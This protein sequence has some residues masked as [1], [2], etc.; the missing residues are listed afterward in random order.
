MLFGIGIAINT[1]H[2][3]QIDGTASA[4]KL[5]PHKGLAALLLLFLF[6]PFGLGLG[7]AGN[8]SGIFGEPAPQEVRPVFSRDRTKLASAAPDGSITV[9]D[10]ESGW[11]FATLG[12]GLGPTT[13]LA[14]SPDSTILAGAN[15]NAVTLWDL[16]DGSEITVLAADPWHTVTGVAFSPRNEVLAAVVDDD[17]IAVWD[18][19]SEAVRAVLARKDEAVKQ[20]AFSADGRFLASHGSGPEITLWD[21]AAQPKSRSLSSPFDAPMTGLAF[22]P[23]GTTLA[24][25][26][27]DG[28]V[29]LW[30]TDTG[31]QTVLTAHID[32]IKRLNFSPNGTMLASEGMDARLVVWDLASG[33][34]LTALPARFDALVS[35]LAF[36]PDG[37]K[38]ASVGDDAELLVWE[39][40]SGRLLHV[41]WGHFGLVEELAFGASGQTL[42]SVGTDGQVIVWDLRTGVE[43][44]VLQHPGLDDAAD[45]AALV[46]DTA[47]VRV[48]NPDATTTAAA[49]TMANA[50]GRAPPDLQVTATKPAETA[51]AGITSLA[52]STDGST[53]ASA[54]E[55]GGIRLWSNTGEEQLVLAGHPGAIASSV[56]FSPNG[57]EFYSAGRDTQLR[58]WERKTAALTQVLLAHE[59]PI[60]A[61]ARSGD[62]NY[63]ASAGEETRV[64]VW[65]AKK[66]KLAHILSGGHKDFVNALAFKPNGNELASAGADGRIL[67]WAVKDGTLTDAL[68]GHAA[69][70]DALAYTGD[71]SMLASG[72]SDATVKLWDTKTGRQ[73]TSLAHPWPVKSIAISA[74]RKTLASAGQGTSIYVWDIQNGG[75]LI[76]VLDG[77]A[78]SVNAL[79]YLPNGRLLVGAEDGTITVWDVDSRQMLQVITPA[80][81]AQTGNM[82]EIPGPLDPECSGLACQQVERVAALSTAASSGNLLLEFAGR[83]LDWL[84]PA[85]S[86]QELRDPN[87]GPGGPILVLYSTSSLFGKYYAEILRT[88]GFNAFS[89]AD[90]ATVTPAALS[91]YD[92]VILAEMPLSADQAIMLTDWVSAG[93]NLIA[94][95][96][97]SQ[98][99]DLFGLT[100]TA[101]PPLSEGYLLIDTSAPPGNGIAGQTMQ[102]HGTATRYQLAGATAVATLYSDASTATDNPAVTLRDVGANG[103]Q[104]AAFAYDLA[105]SVVYT[106]QGNP[107]WANQE[108]DGFVPQRSD[109][110]YYGNAAGDPQADWVDL[111]KVAIPQADEQQRLLAN[112]ILH[113]TRD[114]KPLPRFWY[115]P[116]GEEAVVIMT[117]DDHGNNGTEGRWNQ[118]IAA[119]PAGC[120]V[121]NWECVRGTSY[122]YPSTPIS[123]INAAAF[124]AQGF[125]VGLHINTNCADYTEA[126]LE[127]LYTQQIADFTASW[128]SVLD[129][130]T[131][132]HH[133]IAWTDW[134]TGAKIQLN[135]GVRLDTSYYFWPPTWVLN[136]PGFFNGS[137]MPMRF[138]DLDGTLIDVYQAATQMTDESGQEYP[139][140]VDTLLDRALGTDAYYGA[141]TVNAHTDVAQIPE[142]D[143][144]LASA[145]ARGVPIV[146]SRQMLEWLDGRN[147][148]SFE[149][150]TW[151]GETLGFTVTTGAGA[152]GLRA[153]VPWYAG[154]KLVNSVTRD[155]A[156]I[157]YTRESRKGVEYAGFLA[158]DGTYAVTYLADTTAPTVVSV[159]PSAGSLDV[160]PSTLVTATFSEP[161]DAATI[162]G[163]TFQLAVAS[164]GAPVVAEIS[165]NAETRTATLGPSTSLEPDTT[166]T[167]TVFSGGPADLSGNT[168][169]AD[170]DWSFTTGAL[171]CPCSV[172]TDTDTPAI[173]SAA[174]PNALELGVKFRSDLFGFITGIRFYKGDANTG[175]HVGNLWADDGTLLATAV[176]TNETASGWQQV[177][178]A[179]PGADQREHRLRGLLPCAQRWLCGRLR[180]LRGQRGK[181]I[182]PYTSLQTAKAAA[183]ACICTAREASRPT[184]YGS[185]NYWVDVVFVT[186]HR[187][188]HHAADGDGDVAPRW[189]C[190]RAHGNGCHGDL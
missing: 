129:P 71:G 140:T 37:T 40:S 30:D 106:R 173:P 130:S 136:R 160:G 81:L 69:S 38:L 110:K 48:R 165:Y 47:A 21:L 190:G 89:V 64:M 1:G 113:T 87:Q 119:S 147:G 79:A 151:D 115:F 153:L 17:A 170:V 167:A 92:L 105:T 102:F 145:L 101:D 127:S 36:S 66:G 27:E 112:L 26:D 175:T 99:A 67:R 16:L 77:A 74:N 133:C 162:T 125:E 32:L 163:T 78:S 177:D 100:P 62:G 73:L 19:E 171:G 22:S 142:S 43:R 56:V 24:G 184:T 126:Q 9:L 148:S 164:S 178:F 85:A 91:A 50:P 25:A 72:S 7:A 116:R 168:L 183:T 186:R 108:R 124:E 88:E 8:Q 94:M 3:R 139:F 63:L 5:V 120:S 34:D 75:V 174:D 10:L 11:E 31:E 82:L 138:A 104:A 179:S 103:G 131:Q 44:F 98:L 93:G 187:S 109:D 180:L 128:P 146:T 97:D 132:R 2:G 39:V 95:R 107:A 90:I 172:W 114:Q 61:V 84:V 182:R 70:V 35:G 121:E 176:F 76:R 118:F 185:S 96:P 58:R 123:D 157:Q 33:Q 111:N 13:A 80:P 6:G 29:S 46:N 181:I 68:L 137:G 51:S 152:N 45:P 135:H 12:D 57:N 49:T 14:F 161:M 52:V 149:S 143:A 55:D 117:G 154:A 23:V 169:T 134:V 41:F 150:I 60:R 189:C 156:G 122:M 53:I 20:I 18:L 158:T 83:F 144:V 166:Y 28:T 15:A 86:A 159:S 65:D 141:F 4:S 54:S 155:G 42:S 188:R 59:H